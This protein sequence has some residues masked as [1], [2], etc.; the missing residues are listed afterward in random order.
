MKLDEKT[1]V[2]EPDN[3]DRGAIFM[4][5]SACQIWDL[6]MWANGRISGTIR[7]KD[8]QPLD[9]VTVRAFGFNEKGQRESTALRSSKTDATGVYTLDR[10]PEGDY[11]VGV[12]ADT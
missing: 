11:E 5:P 1:N 2:W 8:N 4:G 7:G 12:N 10:L 9:D 6:A 3:S